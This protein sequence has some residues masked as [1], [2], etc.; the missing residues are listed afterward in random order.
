MKPAGDYLDLV[1]W[2][3]RNL[4]GRTHDRVGQ[5]TDAFVSQGYLWSAI[6]IV[7]GGRVTELASE[8]QQT[9]A[10]IRI[11]NYPAVLA[12]DKLVDQGHGDTWKVLSAARGS[13][14]VLCE[15]ERL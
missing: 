11:R 2:M 8:R 3:K 6:E 10:T 4:A 12:G 5:A 7:T 1:E 14:E 9:T 15:V 13:D